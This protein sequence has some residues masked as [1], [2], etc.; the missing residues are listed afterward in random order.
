MRYVFAAW[1]YWP[2]WYA[3]KSEGHPWIGFLCGSAFVFF[4]LCVLWRYEFG[5]WRFWE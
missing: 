4:A 2:V 5:T 3:F 1:S